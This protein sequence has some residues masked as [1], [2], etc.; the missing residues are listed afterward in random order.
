MGN[1]KDIDACDNCA[2]YPCQ[3]EGCEANCAIWVDFN[4]KEIQAEN[5]KL[6]AK[7]M[8]YNQTTTG[9]AY[10]IPDKI[11]NDDTPDA[12][13]IWIPQNM[14]FHYSWDWLM[15]VI[16]KISNITTP[17]MTD[18]W[19]TLTCDNEHMTMALYNDNIA[20]AYNFV[21][22]FIKFYNLSKEPKCT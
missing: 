14:R 10:I 17:I 20:M 6:I 18:Y 5:N 4:K 7:F 8:E 9:D 15:P 13:D 11:R 16:A 22:V 12:T 3:Y 21:I 1:R 2:K 19:H